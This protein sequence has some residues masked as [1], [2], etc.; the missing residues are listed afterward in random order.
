M[1][2]TQ[3]VIQH[4]GPAADS[5]DVNRRLVGYRAIAR[6]IAPSQLFE[7]VDE[8]AE[9][10]WFCTRNVGPAAEDRYQWWRG[11]PGAGKTALVSSLAADPPDKVRVAAFFAVAQQAG[12]VDAE[13]FTEVMLD[14][15][16]AL[17]GEPTPTASSPERRDAE[18]RRLL[19]LAAAR[20]AAAEEKLLLVV[21][22]LDE[23]VSGFPGSDRRSIASLLP[24][25]P[26]ENVRVLVT[27]RHDP[28]L[29]LDVPD[30]HPLRRLRERVLVTSPFAVGQMRSAQRELLAHLNSGDQTPRDVI[31]FMVVT[32]GGLSLDDLRAF[33]ESHQTALTVLL[34]QSFGRIFVRLRPIGE[35]VDTYQFAHGTLEEVAADYLSS[36]IPSYR[37]RLFECA[38]SYGSAGWPLAT[39]R[40][41]LGPYGRLLIG[42]ADRRML[43]R[44]SRDITRYDCMLAT[45][46]NDHVAFSE[47]ADI[48]LLLVTDCPSP[49]LAALACISL[50]TDRLRHR[51]RQIPARLPALLA[52]LGR[53]VQADALAR[54]IS[55][56]EIRANALVALF[57]VAHHDDTD[58]TLNQ[59]RLVESALDDADQFKR[60][61]IVDRLIENLLSSGQMDLAERVVDK[62][63][64]WADAS[65]H[66]SAL[67]RIAIARAGA[68]PATPCSLLDKAERIA[69]DSPWRVRALCQ[70]AR[71]EAEFDRSRAMQLLATVEAIAATLEEEI[72]SY[73]G[74]QSYTSYP[75]EDARKELAGTLSDLGEVA[76]AER[77]AWLLPGSTRWPTLAKIV[78]ALIPRNRPVALAVVRRIQEL[79]QD[80]RGAML[81]LVPLLRDLGDFEGARAT[82][83]RLVARLEA[84]DGRLWGH[85]A[86]KLAHALLGVD[87]DKAR[88]YA[89]D[90]ENQALSSPDLS[91]YAAVPPQRVQDPKLA[92]VVG[93][94]AAMAEFDRAR[95]LADNITDS[96]WWVASLVEIASAGDL[97]TLTS[98]FR[99][100]D[101]L[102]ENSSPG[103]PDGW[104]S[105]FDR[106]GGGAID[107]S[108]HASWQLD[109]LEASESPA[110]AILRFSALM[111]SRGRFDEAERILRAHP[112]GLRFDGLLQIADEAVDADPSR[113]LRLV[114]E[115]ARMA[116]LVDQDN[117]RIRILPCVISEMAAATVELLPAEQLAQAIPDEAVRVMALTEIAG[118]YLRDGQKDAAARLVQPWKATP[119]SLLDTFTFNGDRRALTALVNIF[120]E[121]G[122]RPPDAWQLV[123]HKRM[124]RQGFDR[125]QNKQWSDLM[126]SH[127]ETAVERGEFPEAVQLGVALTV[128]RLP[129]PSAIARVIRALIRADANEQAEE[130]VEAVTEPYL[131]AR[132]LVAVVEALASTSDLTGAERTAESIAPAREAC[133]AFA[134]LAVAARA[135]APQTAQRF[136]ER[137]MTE[138][139]RID[140]SWGRCTAASDLI[141]TVGPTDPALAIFF[142]E[143]AETLART[144]RTEMQRTIQMASLADALFDATH[145]DAAEAVVR[146][147]P[148]DLTR[149]RHQAALAVRT[150]D[151]ERVLRL[152]ADLPLDLRNTNPAS[153]EESDDLHRIMGQKRKHDGL[154][155]LAATALAACG[156]IDRARDLTLAIDDDQQRAL[157]LAHCAREAAGQ[158]PYLALSLAH[159]AC[160][161]LDHLSDEYGQRARATADV[162]QALATSGD[163]ALGAA[164]R[165]LL[166]T[167]FTRPGWTELLPALNRLDAGA[168]RDLGQAALDVTFG[169]RVPT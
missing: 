88:Q 93:L 19:D 148:D 75:R 154:L 166:A 119:T 107:L 26:P 142:A 121:L 63:P 126:A 109:G 61:P 145:F 104:A 150:R 149:L 66:A 124:G 106:R 30:D 39:P 137:V 101:S 74:H 159:E 161:L 91:E 11:E 123:T 132:L 37:R 134:A 144:L 152:T 16:A 94:W 146:Q 68:N 42:A 48:Q 117:W 108:D 163:P 151:R 80:D 25:R 29:P 62:F 118:A 6:D 45:Y 97:E 138:F 131:R 95:Q 9:L 89:L 2:A 129:Q 160:T 112:D 32:G 35:G 38:D 164:A 156:D 92:A 53:P 67:A 157:S 41:L 17:A 98:I 60:Q 87:D 78:Q 168:I 57:E 153:I 90:A 28:D 133:A 155:E 4:S 162:I 100:L 141:R 77:I 125:A 135:C 59:Y 102:I 86:V 158:R 27:S 139:C 56:A 122:W 143:Q 136:T 73:S 36:E 50:L 33:T 12:Q 31:G 1:V 20:L 22:G 96:A 49:D 120:N 18:R 83:S 24:P 103:P 84:V 44:L 70:V 111:A 8:R 127:A 140:G 14:Q 165:Q 147:I 23:D 55:D 3:I 7:R 116:R 110:R 72:T 115:V 81:E 82:A 79:A 51:N 76:W 21:D 167:A 15:L 46:G 5:V 64:A 34:Q 40:Y 47:L 85:Y 113:A 58:A 43:T 128:V 69:A 10:N 54:S 105:F 130:I 71:V 99:E 114:D 52:R 13:A 65:G 169:T